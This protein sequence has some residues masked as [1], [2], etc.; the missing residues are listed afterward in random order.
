V[1]NIR[2]LIASLTISII[3]AILVLGAIPVKADGDFDI[4]IIPSEQYIEHPDLVAEYNVTVYNNGSE[5][6]EVTLTTSSDEGDNTMCY[7]WYSCFEGGV[8]TYGPFELERG[9]NTTIPVYH[10]II[11]VSE[12]EPPPGTQSNSTFEVRGTA[13][14]GPLWDNETATTHFTY[15]PE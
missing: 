8:P 1:I 12:L 6:L 2:K 9:H 15:W 3:I 11:A 4:V 5:T 7:I 13:T 14:P 10:G